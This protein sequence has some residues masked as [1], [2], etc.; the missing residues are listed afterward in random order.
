M[1]KERNELDESSYGQRHPVCRSFGPRSSATDILPAFAINRSKYLTVYNE[2]VSVMLTRVSA[3]T[4]VIFTTVLLSVVSIGYSTAS[5]G[6]LLTPYAASAGFSL[7]TFASGFANNGNHGPLGIGFNSNG[8]VLVSDYYGDVRLFPNVDGQNGSSVVPAANYGTFSALG[9]TNSG[10]NLYLA[11]HVAHGVVQISSNGTFNQT[12]A[13]GIDFARDI[14]VN[15]NNGHLFVSSHVGIWD[16][17]PVNKTKTLALSGST[18][19]LVIS[20]TT[21]YGSRDFNGPN[22]SFNVIEGFNIGTWTK[23]F[24][25]GRIDTVD[26]LALGSGAL[27]GKI[28]GN[29]NDGKLWEISLSNPINNPNDNKL[30]ASGGSRGDLIRVDPNGNSLLFTQT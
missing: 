15:P 12:I 29:T 22:A 10:G 21:L 20:G 23:V 19:G 26:G 6:I 18:D 2:E 3:S 16:V 30:I 8:G 28:Y 24:D 9:I 27:S 17:D 7:S 14:V 11:T 5:A 13:S 25:S 1:Q 4:R